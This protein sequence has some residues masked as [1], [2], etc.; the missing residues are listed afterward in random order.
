MTTAEI[1]LLLLVVLVAGGGGTAV[2]VLLRGR[3]DF[4]RRAAEAERDAALARQERDAAV[5]SESDLQ[6]KYESMLAERERERGEL[7]E[8]LS[9]ARQRIATLGTQLEE[10]EAAS[11]REFER[12]REEF[13]KLARGSL[14]QQRAAFGDEVVK[15]VDKKLAE[16]QERLVKLSQ[17]LEH[18]A[19]QHDKLRGEYGNLVKALSRPEV[20]GH[21]GE[22]QLRRVV[23]L[24][25]M[26]Q[27]CDFEEQVSGEG[28]DGARQRPDMVV[29]LPNDCS[30]VVDAKCNVDPYMEALSAE[31]DA[32]R[33]RQ[34]DRFADGIGKQAKSLA[35]KRYWNN[36]DPAPEFV[37]MFVPGD[38]FLDAALQRK[39]S[40]IEDA[41]S[42]NVI[43]A[44]PATLIGL[45][46]AVAVGWRQD[47]LAKHAQELLEL[48]RELHGRAATLFEHAEKVGKGLD[49]AVR[50]YNDFVGSLE[51]R[52]MPQLRRFE[53]A[54]TKSAKELPEVKPVERSPRG[55]ALPE[56]PESEQG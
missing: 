20:R 10:R 40:L 15:P 37:V 19:T 16:T 31:D 4:A 34:L 52:F 56:A 33:E 9:E 38:Q 6:S 8:Q 36:F 21:Y 12:L 30:V 7:S 39:W 55:V 48:G 47:T 14:E 2:F 44:S 43:L 41:A 17:Q 51:S 49:G 3:A 25:G 28:A 11:R 42:N 22:M 32:E 24:S 50:S 26:M 45:L 1:V 54:G 46:R 35:D 29:R 18:T 23:E 53:E 27:Y 5:G 13:D